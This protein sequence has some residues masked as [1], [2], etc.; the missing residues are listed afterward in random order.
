MAE[1]SCTSSDVRNC[2]SLTSDVVA[3]DRATYSALNLSITT[4]VPSC[5]PGSE[6]DERL[7][8]QVE[9][10]TNYNTALLKTNLALNILRDFWENTK[11]NSLQTVGVDFIN[12]YRFICSEILSYNDSDCESNS[13]VH[14][15]P[16]D[17]IN[18][19]EVKELAEE[20]VKDENVM[21]SFLADVR[22]WDAFRLLMK[23]HSAALCVVPI[24]DENVLEKHSS[25]QIRANTESD[26]ELVVPV[27]PEA[28]NAPF[29]NNMK[30]KEKKNLQSD[31]KNKRLLR[32]LNNSNAESILQSKL[33][34]LEK[35]NLEKEK[36]WMQEKMELIK[37]FE[38]SK[39]TLTFTTTSSK[40]SDLKSIAS[41]QVQVKSILKKPSS[42]LNTILIKKNIQWDNA[43]LT[44]E[45]EKERS[46][47]ESAILGFY[48]NSG[49]NNASKIA[50][51]ADNSVNY[52]DDVGD[53]SGLEML[54]SRH[55]EPRLKKIAIP[56]VSSS[57]ED[58]SREESK[59]RE[60]GHRRNIEGLSRKASSLP[61]EFFKISN[62]VFYQTK[63]L[64]VKP[65]IGLIKVTDESA[66]V[67]VLSTDKEKN[68][69]N[70]YNSLTSEKHRNDSEGKEELVRN[71]DINSNKEFFEI[72][73]SNT[74]HS[75]LPNLC[76][77]SETVVKNTEEGMLTIEANHIKE[78]EVSVKLES[79]A[80]DIKDT[81]NT[82]LDEFNNSI[83]VTQLTKSSVN[84]ENDIDNL[85]G[86][87]Q[88]NDFID[89]SDITSS[90]MLKIPL[91]EKVEKLKMQKK[92]KENFLKFI[93][94]SN[95]SES[96][97][98]DTSVQIAKNDF[99]TLSSSNTLLTDAG[100]D[101]SELFSNASTLN[102][103]DTCEDYLKRT[104]TCEEIPKK[105]KKR[106]S[107][108]SLSNFDFS[109][110]SIGTSK[111]EVSSPNL[112]SRKKKKNA[113]KQF[114]FA[115]F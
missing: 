95:K 74:N 35:V 114:G 85:L 33:I 39:T 27:I 97:S 30:L 112:Q 111:G 43:V 102:R 38:I 17:P 51:T 109:N 29:N 64:D 16:L 93:K 31:V 92:W 107:A 53:V 103:T 40:H 59:Q 45:A 94:R 28:E 110:I 115:L 88:F 100:I 36:Q 6:G 108:F 55:T 22:D 48:R 62:E 19:E 105:A 84:T 9:T 8:W 79:V 42:D 113:K 1:T 65:K 81:I 13:V 72:G 23:R 52:E 50:F 14:N 56:G 7:F 2:S 89:D 71:E 12:F 57:K 87:S 106:F 32:V 18:D 82:D 80:S 69:D 15:L 11:A 91:Q 86:Q 20:L 44:A 104:D 37:Q 25:S 46:R 58:R 21:N 98:T 78:I 4:P 96:F 60:I 5:S 26:Y 77:E 41:N 70:I 3:I 76:G 99:R 47:L 24:E 67:N 83:C 61:E 49:L 73:S 34:A 90:E 54:R 66:V 75:C 63:E 101:E 10:A 68:D